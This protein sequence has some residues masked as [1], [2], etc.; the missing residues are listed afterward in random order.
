MKKHLT[1]FKCLLDEHSVLILLTDCWRYGSVCETL[2]VKL[3]YHQP[4]I[5]RSWSAWLVR[6]MLLHWHCFG[7]C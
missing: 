6:N 7:R 1:W 2:I 4:D 3:S 5:R